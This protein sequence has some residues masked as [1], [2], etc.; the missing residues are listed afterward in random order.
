[1]KRKRYPSQI[2]YEK[3]NPTITVRMKLHEKEKIEEMAKKTGK[4]I[5][6]L[7][8]IALLN[9]E[10]DFSATIIKS[11]D[12]GKLEGE[13][14]GYQKGRAEGY[15]NGRYEWAIWYTYPKCGKPLFIKPNSKDHY[16]SVKVM[17]GRLSHTQ[18]PR[19]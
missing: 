8:R 9:L 17:N 2:K 19:E 6:T 4:R 3:N 13:I 16:E 18:C 7:I 12:D 14:I 15:K 1:M 11:K 10:K 5:S